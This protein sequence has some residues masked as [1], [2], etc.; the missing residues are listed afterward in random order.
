MG[1]PRIPERAADGGRLEQRGSADQA[2]IPEGSRNE[3]FPLP[4]ALRH[5]AER[6][7]LHAARG[8]DLA[9]RGAL[10]REETGEDRSP[11]EIDSL[12]RRRGLREGPV[13]LRER[14]ERAPHLRGRHRTEPRSPSG[15]IRPLTSERL[16]G[17]DSDQFA[18]AVVV[19]CEDHL[20]RPLGEAPQSVVQ[21]GRR[22]VADRF[23]VDEDVQVGVLP[24]V[25]L[26]RIVDFHDVPA[27][28]ENDH[29]VTGP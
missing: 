9:V 17:L 27:K 22:F 5:K 3:V 1:R 7:S 4:F 8:E 6:G 28:R 14:L 16:E 11:R 21:R 13:R 10:Q 18:L 23:H 15:Q 26:S 19:G 25:R 24:I 2:D 12:P 20:V 29:V